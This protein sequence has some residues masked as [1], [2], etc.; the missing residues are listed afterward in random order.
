MNKNNSSEN[1]EMEGLMGEKNPKKNQPMSKVLNFQRPKNQ[2]AIAQENFKENVQ[3]SLPPQKQN[4]KKWRVV[5]EFGK[6]LY[7]IICKQYNING[8]FKIFSFNMH[9]KVS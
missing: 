6:I 9:Q 4:I 2:R 3:N 1:C 7:F 5:Q 8:C